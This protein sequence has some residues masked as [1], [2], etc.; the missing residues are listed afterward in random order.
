MSNIDLAA[1]AERPDSLTGIVFDLIRDA[2]INKSIPPG[3]I[4][5]E[6]QLAKQLNVSKTPVR[7]SLI[8]LQHIG[9]LESDGRRL[10]VITPSFKALQNAYEMR[11]C[12][13]PAGARYAA[14]R[15][16]RD[17]IAAI[18][19]AAEETLRCAEEHDHAGYSAAS[20]SFHRAVVAASGN[21]LL[22]QAVEHG[23]ILT[24][25]LWRRDSSKPNGRA[26]SG[27][28]HLEI[29]HAIATG[30]EEK[31]AAVMREHT[32]TLLAAVLAA[33]PKE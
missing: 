33:F 26:A 15:A 28:Q 1:V 6:A 25:T 2:I 18:S 13:E 4:L 20:R 3:S 27:R 32:E 17:E 19:Q 29:A 5:S 16:T 14:T 24:Q 10:R 31:A 7:E 22:K 21:D 30:D 9:L 23:L 12:L 11:S 8:R